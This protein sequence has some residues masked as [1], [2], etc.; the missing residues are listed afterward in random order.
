M[1]RIKY[2][3]LVTAINGTSGGT[4]FQRNLY[5]NTL[6]NKPAMNIPRTSY[7]NQMKVIMQTV[8]GRWRNLTNAQRQSWVNYVNTYPTPTRL[9]ADAYLNA[10][11]F[12]MKYNE[13]RARAGQPVL[14]TVSLTQNGISITDVGMS[15]DGLDY[16]HEFAPG[17]ISPNWYIIVFISQ[18]IQGFTTPKTNRTRFIRSYNNLAG[19]T[20]ANC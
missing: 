15:F 8:A 6:K 9:N 1:A 11:N 12:F 2:S 16:Y 17:L 5:G 19:Q 14:E 4:T 20:Q 13:L 10:F 18:R 7:Q 3:A